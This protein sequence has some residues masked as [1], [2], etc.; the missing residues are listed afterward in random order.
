VNSGYAADGSYA[1]H[2]VTD[3]RYGVDVPAAVSSLEAAPLTCAGITTF[4]PI[5]VA[6]VQS[7]ET[8]SVAS[9]GGLGHLALQYVR[10]LG[11]QVIAVDVE[12]AK[13]D[14]APSARG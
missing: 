3:D 6:H 12:E 1:E 7:G 8:V 10:V 13:L 2:A 14:L 11:A 9:I 4:K 5:K